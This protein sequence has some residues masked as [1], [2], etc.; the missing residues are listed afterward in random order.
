M[1]ILQNNEKRMEKSNI[2]EISDSESPSS[3]P[4]KAKPDI[5]TLVWSAICTIFGSKLFGA[6]SLVLTAL[7]P[8]FKEKKE[9]F[10][11]A[12]R[13]INVIVTLLCITPKIIVLP[14]VIV[15]LPYLLIFAGAS[16]GVS[17]T[18]LVSLPFMLIFGIIFMP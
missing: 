11:T 5:P 6:L 4:K 16:I 18:F 8:C 2:K 3:D 7:A 9:A 12:G 14:I 10:V 17:L 13:A 15:V 1:D